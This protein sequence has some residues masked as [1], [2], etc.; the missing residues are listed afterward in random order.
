[1]GRRKKIK[2]LQNTKDGQTFK[3]IRV[4]LKSILF[5][6]FWILC[7]ILEQ[8]GTDQYILLVYYFVYLPRI[9]VLSNHDFEQNNF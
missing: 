7:R 5:K 3:L 9:C 6:Y 8:H 1:M 2:L 4:L